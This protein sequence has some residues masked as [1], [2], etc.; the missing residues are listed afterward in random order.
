LRTFDGVHPVVVT[1][2]DSSHVDL[3]R[4]GASPL[5]AVYQYLPLIPKPVG[6]PMPTLGLGDVLGLDLYVVTPS[7][8]LSDA[9]VAERI[10]WKEE[11][12]EYW[13]RQADSVGKQL[14]VTEMQAAPWYETTGFTIN[15]LLASA[16]LYRHGGASVVLLWGVEGWLSDPDWMAAGKQAVHILRAP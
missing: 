15:D 14:W 1:T 11:A 12:L 5:A 4:V 13:V 2:Y 9:G 6:H 3:D 16:Y 8:P 10:G 7:T